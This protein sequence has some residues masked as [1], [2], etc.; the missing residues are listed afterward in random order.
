MNFIQLMKYKIKNCRHICTFCKHKKKCHFEL[1][2]YPK[3]NIFDILII[4]ISVIAYILGLIYII[5][6]GYAM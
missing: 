6:C 5:C 4:L 2:Y 1:G 3:L